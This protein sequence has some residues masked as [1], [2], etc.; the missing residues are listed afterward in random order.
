[1]YFV[2]QIQ[3]MLLFVSVA[4]SWKVTTNANMRGTAD[5]TQVWT[6]G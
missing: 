2:L 6:E 1:M 3:I 4:A 5:S